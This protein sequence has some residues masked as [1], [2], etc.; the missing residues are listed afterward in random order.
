MLHLILLCK[1]LTAGLNDADST[2]LSILLKVVS[3]QEFFFVNV[4][5]G[6]MHIN[7]PIPDRPTCNLSIGNMRW[8]SEFLITVLPRLSGLVGT[9]FLQN[10]NG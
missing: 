4:H 3:F 2:F 1:I 8:L 7:I 9:A 10:L 5:Y 6:Q